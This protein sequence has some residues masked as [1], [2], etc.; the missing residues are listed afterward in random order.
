VDE[1]LREFGARLRDEEARF[2]DYRAIEEKT[3]ELGFATSE[4]TLRFYV[5]EGVLPPP[6]RRG[7]RTP[8]Y[9]E[10]WILNVLLAL[11]V[12][13][14]R[15]GRSL[16]EAREVLRNLREDPTALA[17]KLSVLY[18]DYVRGE[19]RP[20]S[21]SRLV[22][23][24]FARLAGGDGRAAAQP[25][26]VSILDLVRAIEKEG[27]ERA[28]SN[29][30]P[31]PA[32]PKKPEAP[33]PAEA[34]PDAEARAHDRE[35]VERRPKPEGE[36]LLR[37]EGYQVDKVLG[38]GAMGDVF[39]GTYVGPDAEPAAPS[40]PEKPPAAPVA[41]RV[42]PVSLPEGAV[43][44]DKA[45]AL[46]ELFIGRFDESLAELRRVPHPIEQQL[47][48]AGARDR[49]HLKRTRADEVI[50]LM[51]R[52][53]IYERELLEALPLDEISE[54]RMFT[55]SIFGKK[56]VRVVLA[57]C[58]VSPLEDFIV[59][60]CSTRR[61]GPSE[62]DRVLD[63]VGP[64]EGVFYYIGV[65]STTGWQPGIERHIPAAQN[66]LCAL[67]ENRGGTG[68]HLRFHEDD[69]WGGLARLFDPE[70]ERE[71]VERVR[72]A[73]ATHPELMLRGGHVILKNL[74][75]DLGVPEPILAQAVREVLA[76]D[77][78]LSLL[79]VGGKEILKRRRL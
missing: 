27:G 5:T 68:W 48:P 18:E 79:E 8:V 67:V 40:A 62:L 3:R 47:Y 21:S 44:V 33:K 13:K 20:A 26:E 30:V 77:E 17:D 55:R 51:K 59:K 16:A 1:R 45:K 58:C 15:L 22:D 60:K 25:S 46:E 9:E 4:R 52:H 63:A 41:A 31:K 72:R 29:E 34:A 37:E 32:E 49:I 6:A 76:S 38:L 11:H 73:L 14:T 56:D 35:A 66:V 42:T 12:M 70:S 53:R 36:E 57:A 75:A 69:R 28:V 23:A 7:G 24:F 74:R 43:L 78:D 61:G 64:R 19:A 71:K 39:Q 10:D 54:Y 2:L 50:D 65:L